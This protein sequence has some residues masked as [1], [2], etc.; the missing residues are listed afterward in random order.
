MFESSCLI[1]RNRLIPG[2]LMNR[3]RW[4]E[5]MK[6]GDGSFVVCDFLVISTKIIPEALRGKNWKALSALKTVSPSPEH[7]LNRW[8]C[9]CRG[10]TPILSC[11]KWVPVQQILQNLWV[12]GERTRKTALMFGRWGSPPKFYA[13]IFWCN[14][15][16]W[17][18]G[19]STFCF[20]LGAPA[21]RQRAAFCRR[22]GLACA[23]W[24]CCA[25]RLQTLE[26][27]L[28]TPAPWYSSRAF[29]RGQGTN[30]LALRL[31][32]AYWEAQPEAPRW[33]SGQRKKGGV[34]WATFR[35]RS[36][37]HIAWFNI[38]DVSGPQF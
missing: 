4:E 1:N 5:L 9:T 35:R 6:T 2:E 33:C 37:E 3:R 30:L 13:Y 8:K 32:C 11:C 34:S 31:A 21:R 29:K 12:G 28:S 22:P 10:Q 14:L 38:L 23:H 16:P 36:R 25:R 15:Q 19:L 20:Q 7:R 17:G 26:M 24:M 27:P 18:K